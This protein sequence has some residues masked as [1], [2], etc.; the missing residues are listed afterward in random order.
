MGKSFANIFVSDWVR[1]DY[2][3]FKLGLN[4]SL[5]NFLTP[6]KNL[7]HANVGIMPHFKGICY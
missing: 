6:W 4:F 5:Q 7:V 3:Y 1:E 2:V